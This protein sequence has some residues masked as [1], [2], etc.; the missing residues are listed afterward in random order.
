MENPQMFQSEVI[1]RLPRHTIMSLQNI[2]HMLIRQG[3]DKF[4]YDSGL[5]FGPL[6]DDPN[7]LK[8]LQDETYVDAMSL[9]A[10]ITAHADVFMTS[11]FTLEFGDDQQG[12]GGNC[13]CGFSDNF[14]PDDPFG[15][16]DFE[17][18]DLN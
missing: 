16:I 10:S 8:K 3:K 6:V 18:F 12:C 11:D 14:A 15:G 2:L 17:G 9:F 4:D 7:I 1:I 5:V 13:Q